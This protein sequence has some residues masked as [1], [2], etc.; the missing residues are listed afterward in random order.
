L[1]RNSAGLTPEQSGVFYYNNI[2]GEVNVEENT[3]ERLGDP[4]ISLKT[5]VKGLIFMFKIRHFGITD[6]NC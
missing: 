3:K 1:K 2:G 5:W 4:L 6:V